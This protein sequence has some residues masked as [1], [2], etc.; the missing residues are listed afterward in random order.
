MLTSTE[1]NNRELQNLYNFCKT[2]NDSFKFNL[3]IAEFKS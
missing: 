1:D 3:I 2:D